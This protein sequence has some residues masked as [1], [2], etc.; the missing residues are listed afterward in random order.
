VVDH[1][2]SGVERAWSA[3][4][5]AA[6]AITVRHLLQHTSGIHDDDPSLDTPQQYLERRFPPTCPKSWWPAP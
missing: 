6:N 2:V 3:H 4:E 5:P 1:A